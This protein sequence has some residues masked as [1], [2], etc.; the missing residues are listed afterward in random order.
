[1]NPFKTRSKPIL[2]N[3]V[4]NWYDEIT[5]KF[6]KE[7]SIK[8]IRLKAHLDILIY[9]PIRHRN[10]D[11]IYIISKALLKLRSNSNPSKVHNYHLVKISQK[12]ISH[13]I[14]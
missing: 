12:K 9:V 14:L 8:F 4:V 11:Y 2:K 10:F 7:K 5:L 1:M 6:F 13:L 3:V